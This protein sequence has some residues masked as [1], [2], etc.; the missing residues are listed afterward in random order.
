MIGADLRSG[1]PAAIALG[2]TL[3]NA[4]G[5]RVTFAGGKAEVTDGPF[6]DT[7]ETLG[8]YWMI[9]V[10]SREEAIK[11]AMRCPASANET[12]EIRRVQEMADFADP[13]YGDTLERGA[14]LS[15]KIKSK[16]G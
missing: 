4:A 12:I 10:A 13:K 8:G 1:V 16:A 15:Q 9:Q 3:T 2:A 5:A 14:E 6:P 7:T 11:W